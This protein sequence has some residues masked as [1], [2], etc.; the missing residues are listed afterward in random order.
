LK[1]EIPVFINSN[2]NP[3]S[4]AR[5]IGRP[6]ILDGAM[7]SLLQQKAEKD[8]DVWMSKVSLEKPELVF[9]VHKEYIEAGADIITTNTFRT[10]PAAAKNSG[11]SSELLVKKNVELAK[12]AVKNYPV[13]VAGSNAPAEDCYQ[14][15]RT[16]SSKELEYNHHK[17]IDLL[18]ENGVDFILNETH[19]HF[20]EIKIIC[21]YCSRNN[22]PFVVS[23]FS[24]DGYYL[25]DDYLVTDAI[26]FII[27]TNPMAISFNCINSD[28]FFTILNESVFNY[29]WGVYMN[30]GTGDYTNDIIKNSVSPRHY[31]KILKSVFH[32]KPSFIGACCGSNPSHIKELRDLF[33]E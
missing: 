19:S 21:E 23:L 25:L 12:R 9:E 16:I 4:F 22:I 26:N 2:I 33:N 27:S 24:I 15:E 29:N 13:F 7:G 5:R 10:N 20:D 28:V 17:H 6:L 3:F 30:L 8:P 18:L 32:R 1:E 31:L 14:K 11:V